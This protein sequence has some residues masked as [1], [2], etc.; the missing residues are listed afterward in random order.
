MSGRDEEFRAFV[1]ARRPVLLRLARLL[2]AGDHHHAEDLVQAALE[3]L[4]L[5]WPRVQRAGGADAYARKVLVN[6][7]VDES[8]RPWRRERARPRL[9]DVA[10]PPDLA[11]PEGQPHDE[12]AVVRAALAE[13]PA[14]MRAAVVLRHW[15]GLDVREAA[16]LLGC[17]EGTVKSSTARGL[18]RLRELLSPLSLLAAEAPHE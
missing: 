18:Q 8:R 3:R 10:A 14:G 16:V 6:V 9:P 2:A 1:A 17:S 4:Y 15:L 7:A 13:L 11:G 12:R 5:A